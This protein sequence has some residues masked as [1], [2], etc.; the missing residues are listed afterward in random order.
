MKRRWMAT[1]ESSDGGGGDDDDAKLVTC[2]G[3]R[4][5]FYCDVSKRSV[6]RLVDKLDEAASNALAAAHPREDARVLLYIHSDGGEA[7]AALSAMAHIRA[8]KVRV[9]TVADGFVASAA[10]LLFLSADERYVIPH[11]HV[12]I[13]QLRTAFWGKFDELLDEVSNSRMLMDTIMQIYRT[14]T[15]LGNKKISTLLRKELN[16][17]AEQCVQHGLAAG[18]L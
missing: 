11:A 7:Y 9:V 18:V 17:N 6:L 4:V 15:K 12:L 1:D 3:T 14:R 2:R 8:C 16:M 5:F 13:H 10:T